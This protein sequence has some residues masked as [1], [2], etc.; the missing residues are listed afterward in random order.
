[1]KIY[2]IFDTHF[3]ILLHTYKKH[4]QIDPTKPAEPEQT[5]YPESERGE[6]TS[7]SRLRLKLIE[8]ITGT[9]SFCRFEGAKRLTKEKE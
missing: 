4:V 9:T 2:M 3:L 8:K 7:I 5:S 6:S 1:L